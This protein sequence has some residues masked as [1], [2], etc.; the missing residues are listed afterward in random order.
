MDG[1][2]RSPLRYQTS[3][4]IG[5]AYFPSFRCARSFAMRPTDAVNV[6]IFGPIFRNA[7]LAVHVPE[8]CIRVATAWRR[9]KPLTL[10]TMV[11]RCI[12]RVPS[13]MKA[14]ERHRSLLRCILPD[15]GVV[16][17][18]NASDRNSWNKRKA[19]EMG[20]W[21]GSWPKE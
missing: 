10:S 13:E 2:L 5:M 17:N 18:S 9:S 11:G 4:E 6:H 3:S 21:M 12:S 20:D 15:M 8:L 1:Y 7:I 14:A 19:I 16:T